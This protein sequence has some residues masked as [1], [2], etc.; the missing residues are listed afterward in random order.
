MHQWATGRSRLGRGVLS[1]IGFD[2]LPQALED[3]RPSQN[4]GSV[5]SICPL[6]P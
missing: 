4:H 2:L 1:S 5:A 3:F 6:L